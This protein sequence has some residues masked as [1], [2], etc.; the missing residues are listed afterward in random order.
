MTYNKFDAEYYVMSADG[1]NNHPLLNWGDTDYAAFRKKEIIDE[2]ELDLPLKIIFDKPYP[3]E[4]C[5]IADFLSLGI[6]NAGS[7]K[8]KSLFTKWGISGVQ[9]IPVA[10]KSNK[11]KII[12]GHYALHFWN[13]LRAI[14]IYEAIKAEGLTGIAFFRVDQWDDN[15]MFR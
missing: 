6:Q 7:E 12:N 2:T 15:A 5:E 4:P 13:R 1:A 14:D 8:L 10:I 11:G 3:K 9:F